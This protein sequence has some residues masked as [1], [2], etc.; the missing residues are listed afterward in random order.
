MGEGELSSV[1]ITPNTLSHN[2]KGVFGGTTVCT[3]L[4]CSEDAEDLN[5]PMLKKALHFY[6]DPSQ[7]PKVLLDCKAKIQAADAFIVITAE[8]NTGMPPAL[9]NML[10]HFGPKS[11]SYK[12]SGI[13]SYSVGI[14]GGV[15]AAMQLRCFLGEIGTL[16]V[17][18]VFAIPEIHNALD[19]NGK[20]LNEHMVTG[21]DHMISQLDW[22]AH[23][24]KNHRNMTGVPKYI[25][26]SDIIYE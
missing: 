14:F 13:I 4:Q 9:S 11:F 5:L 21:L 26:K 1:N 7:A 19:E 6:E 20:P 15:R 18:N 12:P 25:P 17:S 3:C 22:Y 8:Y 16:S 10:N 23:A 24:M 2:A